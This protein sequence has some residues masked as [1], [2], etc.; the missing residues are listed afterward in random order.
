MVQQ[1]RERALR[2]LVAALLNSDLSNEEMRELARALKTDRSLSAQLAGLLDGVT[3]NLTVSP[4]PK[5]KG[6]P[7]KVPEGAVMSAKE[8]IRAAEK[9]DLPKS[10]F[11][12]R[13]QSFA[14]QPD[15]NPSHKSALR[16]IAFEFTRTAPRSSWQPALVAL[17]AGPVENDPYVEMLSK[18]ETRDKASNE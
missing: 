8:F 14:Q 2:A 4:E 12:H 17:Q 3:V 6:P 13:L 9:A 1:T 15:W 7:K 10:V 16:E 5:H 18:K 11:I